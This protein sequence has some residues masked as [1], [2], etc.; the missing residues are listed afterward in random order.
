[1]SASLKGKSVIVTGG[2]KGIGKG[3]AKVFAG[4]GAK[5]LIAARQ[6]KDAEA[7]AQELTKAGGTASAFAA[8]A[9]SSTLNP[10]AAASRTC[11]HL[12]KCGLKP[13][14][15]KSAKAPNASPAVHAAR[16]AVAAARMRPRAA[17]NGVN[18]RRT[19]STPRSFLK[20]HGPPRGAR[21]KPRSSA[22]RLAKNA[23]RFC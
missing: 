6:L 16:I 12:R 13:R 7:T 19:A 1:M 15:A 21:R 18:A 17:T 11:S 20:R 2:S 10:R 3:I 9:P 23:T 8:D 14:I 22:M 5:V 4:F